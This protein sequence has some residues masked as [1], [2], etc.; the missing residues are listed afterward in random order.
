MG[1]K[2]IINNQHWGLIHKNEAFKFLRPGKEGKGFIKEIR[3]DGKLSL[4]LQPVGKEAAVGLHEQILNKLRENGGVLAVS[5]KSPPEVIAGLFSVSKGN[6]KKAIG[7]LYKQGE[8][9]IH[10]DRIEL[11]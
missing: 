7:A 2:A 10:A 1:F 3:P 11:P 9:V 8:L 4:S 5:D 6:F